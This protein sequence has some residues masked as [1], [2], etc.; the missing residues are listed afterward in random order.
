MEAIAARTASTKTVTSRRVTNSGIS[1]T[2]RQDG[3]VERR[4][5][6]CDADAAPVMSTAPHLAPLKVQ[7][8]EGQNG[9]PNLIALRGHV[10]PNE[11][12]TPRELH[13]LKLHQ[14]VP[15]TM[16]PAVGQERLIR[17]PPT[18]TLDW[19]SGG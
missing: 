9:H 15:L 14:Y 1:M 5:G 3:D 6:L 7:R 12:C 19:P 16:F 2:R 10:Q 18:E 13:A 8:E 4:A 11:G 17:S